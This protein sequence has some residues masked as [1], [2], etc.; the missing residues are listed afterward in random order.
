MTE[1]KVIK[2]RKELRDR[3][4]SDKIANDVSQFKLKQTFKPILPVLEDQ[5]QKMQEMV[6]SQRR[7]TY[8]IKTEIRKQP[9]IIPLIKSL[10]N[11]PKI[12]SFI[13]GELD[14]SD[15]DND[16]KHILKQI[17]RVD[18][19]TLK[20]LVEY[21]S[22][23]EARSDIESYLTKDS[24]VS[25]ESREI[26]ENVFQA[27]K[28]EIRQIFLEQDNRDKFLSYLAEINYQFDL[29]RKPFTT[30]KAANPDFYKEIMELRKAKTGKGAFVKF[31]SSDPKE[32][33]NKLNLLIAEKQAGNNNVLNEA[34]A[35]VDE[36]RRVGA[37]SI[38]ECKQLYKQFN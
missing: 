26:F 24:G 31:L 29:N 21:Y 37:I 8:D 15:L 34:S 10:N 35:V 18:D 19:T 20:I 36:L 5:K 9:L 1:Q 3:S 27:N 33:L 2:L 11:Y 16:E 32:L 25:N 4:L 22:E 13:N 7:Q 30:I 38:S 17:G 23:P 14:D 12:I 6:Q 28:D